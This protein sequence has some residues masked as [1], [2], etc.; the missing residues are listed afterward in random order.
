MF[1]GL[2][3][4]QELIHNHLPIFVALALLLIVLIVILEMYVLNA[5]LLIFLTQLIVNAFQHAQQ[6]TMV[7]MLFLLQFV[8]FVPINVNHV[9]LL[10]FVAHAPQLELT[11]HF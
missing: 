4:H 5:K 9:H 1:L 8:P 6:A 2:I 7:T 10:L 11:N 3:V